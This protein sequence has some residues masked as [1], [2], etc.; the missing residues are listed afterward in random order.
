MRP[1]HRFSLAS[2]LSLSLTACDTNPS[3]ILS[4]IDPTPATAIGT[5]P[6]QP[7][8]ASTVIAGKVGDV[9]PLI[10]A[11]A[12]EV[13]DETGIIWVLSN[14]RAPVKNS[15]VKIHGTLRTMQGEHY[16]AQ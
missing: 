4:G 1:M 11:V 3:Q 8:G 5:L 2:I 9:A 6:S 12:F 7:D 10:G 13:Q 14:S 16:I 15:Q